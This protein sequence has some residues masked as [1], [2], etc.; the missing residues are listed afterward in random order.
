LAI[1]AERGGILPLGGGVK[2]GAPLQKNLAGAP[3]CLIHENLIII[4]RNNLL[5]HTANNK[6][7]TEDCRVAILTELPLAMTAHLY[8]LQEK[9][10]AQ[11]QSLLCRL[12]PTRARNAPAT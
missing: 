12:N 3:W 1:R 4:F 6:R 8:E 2:G 10:F 9:N 7:E 5:P 11:D